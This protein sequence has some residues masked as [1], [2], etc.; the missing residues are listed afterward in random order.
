MA[1]LTSRLILSLTDGVTGPARGIGAALNRLHRQGQ[2]TSG[3]LIGAGSGMVGGTVRNMLAIGAGYVGVQK[4]MSGTIGAAI[5]FEESF[6]D[7]RKVFS[8]TPAQLEQIRHE[9][10]AMS[11]TMPTSAEGLSAIFAAA[12]QANIPTKE[13]GKFSEMVAKV[14]VAWDTSEGETSQALAEIKNQLKLG[15]DD[16]GLYADAINHLS[17]NTAARA[18]ALVDFSKRV[19]ANGEMFGFAATESLAFGS[20]MIA[21]GAQ[22]E[23]AAT[24]FRNM[25]RALTIGARATKMQR[26]AFSRLGLDSIKTA[27]AMQKNALGTTLDVLDRIQKLPEWERISIASALFGDEARALMPV[28]ANTTELRRQLGLVANEADYS[29]SAFDEYLERAKTTGNALD[30]IGNKIRAVGIGIGDGWLPTIKE[31]G[32]G[33]G[34]VLDTLDKRVGVFDKVST[35]FSGFMTGLGYGGKAGPRDFINDLGDLI[36]GRAFDGSVRDADARVTALAKLS[37]QMRKIGRDLRSFGEDIAAGN[38]SGAVTS[39]GDALSGL[40]GGMT[41]GGGIA[42]GAVGWGLLLIA[43]GA[44]ALTTSRIGQIAL[45]ATAIAKIIDAAKGSE[46]LGEFAGNLS[47]LSA[48][49]WAI[50]AGGLGLV[51]AK[52]WRIARGLR[53]IKGAGGVEAA[54]PK[55]TKPNA[56]TPPKQGG[57]PSASST[58]GLNAKPTKGFQSPWTPGAESTGG[59]ARPPV[60]GPTGTPVARPPV[61]APMMEFPPTASAPSGLGAGLKSFFGKGGLLGTGLTWLGEEAIA[62]G[63]GRLNSSLYTPEQR[64][65]AADKLGTRTRT[66][67]LGNEVAEMP[68]LLDRLRNLDNMLA[69]MFPSLRANTGS[70]PTDVD[71]I[72]TP[73]VSVPS[74]VTTQPSGVQQ[75]TVTNPPPRPNINVSVSMTV[76]EATNGAQLARQFG[77]EIRGALSGVQSDV[78]YAPGM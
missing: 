50:V 61:P 25:G 18:P 64:A 22:S 78:E 29:G 14:A 26:T 68:S 31:L 74:P 77:D 70:G 16:I 67:W 43:R 32:L 60:R 73:E 7:V 13:I 23:V 40:S 8:G 21:Q 54:S 30:I 35:A 19:A 39:L 41:I 49:D 28:I 71:V 65:A 69:D 3:A 55:P 33:L 63:V 76:N 27:K 17:N 36:F 1:T 52:I 44:I 24:S 37:N 62:A 58:P 20:A 46:S 6:A 53:A 2:R 12:A 34:D 57:K 15:V 9:I 4:A 47:Q 38:I 42:L 51:G 48:F 59:Q 66:T 11:K 56:A 45:A 72:G 10:L 5:K 75:V